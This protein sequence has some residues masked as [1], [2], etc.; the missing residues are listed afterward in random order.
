MVVYSLRPLTFG[1]LFT[2]RP[3]KAPEHIPSIF[4]E[5]KPRAA[6]AGCS[7]QWR[8]TLGSTEKGAEARLRLS[9][10]P[11]SLTPLLQRDPGI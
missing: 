6:L 11:Q 10:D 8:A 7:A 4:L 2:T 9:L 5:H 3:H 1:D